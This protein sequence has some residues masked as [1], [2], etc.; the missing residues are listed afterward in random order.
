MQP[1]NV[2][3]NGAIWAI[4]TYGLSL[5]LRLGSNIVLSRLLSP[6]LL[7]I[8]VV[9]N[10]LRL[11]IELLSDVGI[12]QNIV[13]NQAGAKADFLNTAW[14]MQILRGFILTSIF[15]ALSPTLSDF[16]RIELG[17][18]IGVAFCPFIG[19]LHS[20]SIF[21]LVRNL[22]VRRRNLF[23]IANELGAFCVTVALAW[24]WRDVWSVVIGVLLS[25]ALRS[26][27]SYYL[28]H[29]R[30]RF[31]L[32]GEHV[33]AI[34]GFGKWIAISSLVN[35]T[36]G[37]ADKIYLGK[38][39]PLDSLG[40]YGLARTISDLPA[41]LTSRL[42]YQVLFPFISASANLGRP[43][44]IGALARIRLKFVLLAS[45][46]ISI[47]IACSDYAVALLYDDRYQSAGWML[48]ILLIGSWFGVLSG[49]NEIKILSSEKPVYQSVA[50]GV[51][52]AVL[53]V[54]LAA[55]TSAFGLAGTVCAIPLAEVCRYLTLAFAQYRVRSAFFGQDLFATAILIC[56]T[57]I[58]YLLREYF[59][60]GHPWA[61]IL[62]M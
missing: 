2:I 40:T 21:L 60:L 35:F 5:S 8:M 41:I 38:A 44:L 45:V 29:P 1:R 7:G 10:A 49:L 50:S 16:Y 43:S 24:L 33:R 30:H 19:S 23:E 25:C 32:L 51:R 4:G 13:K 34:L 27:T 61:G 56:L 55:G 22:E 12:E 48:C 62:S 20:T 42:A 14:T 26:A 31:V 46:G 6:E 11:G 59:D 15:L 52:L 36:A 28:P 53:V 54:G 18:F 47:G 9:V 17:V 3:Q 37:N 58:W 39:I 57:F